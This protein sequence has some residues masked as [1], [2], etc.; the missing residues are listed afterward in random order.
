MVDRARI[1]RSTAFRLAVTYLAFF[2]ATALLLLGGVYWTSTRFIDSQTR[3]TINAEITGL[4]ERYR[5][6]GVTGLVQVIRDRSAGE[7]DRKSLYLL[8][9]DL[10]RPVAGNLLGWPESDPDAEGWLAFPVQNVT[11]HGLQTFEATGRM[12][13]LPGGYRLLVGR[14]LQD[15]EEVKSVLRRAIGFGV[16]LTAL[17]GLAG[18]ALTARKLLQRVEAI[19]RTMRRIMAGDISQRVAERGRGDEFDQLAAGFNAALDQ[20]E[21]L[22]DSIRTVTDNIAHD[23]RTPLHR[24]RSRIDV[25]LLA[26]SAETEDYRKALEE[27]M[28]DA[29]RLLATFNA[30]LTIAQAEAGARAHP[31]QPVDL[32]PLVRDVAE[33]YE[34]LAED[35]GLRFQLRTEGCET[36]LGDRHLLSQALANLLDNAVKYTPAGGTVRLSVEPGPQV[37]VADSGPGIP[38]EARTKVLERFVRLD[39]TRSTPGNG[40]GLSLVDAVARLHGARL[41]LADAGPGLLV[42]LSFKAAGAGPAPAA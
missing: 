29:D 38:A 7:R 20:I 17:L 37:V 14:S 10:Y 36:V 39:A 32:V 5:Q 18:G 22:V 40:L 11:A 25:A 12:F 9:D 26:E 4:A 28:A 42:R 23:L 19:N 41:E 16:G 24:L 1:L 3:E 34:P 31:L 8:T 27:T 6:Q 2:A 13:D 33:L 21:R 15:A 35:K 30:L